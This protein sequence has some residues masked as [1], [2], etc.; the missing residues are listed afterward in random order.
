MTPLVIVSKISSILT[1]VAQAL[2]VLLIVSALIP[3]LRKGCIGHFLS[4]NGTWMALVVATAATILSLMY[5]EVV[6]FE[7][8]RLC[9]FQRIVIFPQV[10]IL[11]M[12]WV[13]NQGSV[14]RDYSIMLAVIGVVISARH[15]LLQVLQSSANCDA[16]AVSCSAKYVF[17]FGYITIPMMALTA[18]L[19][20][21]ALQLWVPRTKTN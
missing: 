14:I 6:G 8:C 9:W 11:G 20:I 15:Y 1:V 2:L 16:L 3:R 17:H 21:I 5:S 19:L 7:P 12:A 4:Q 13:R 18:G 10:F